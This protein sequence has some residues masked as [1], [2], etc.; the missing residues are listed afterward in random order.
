MPNDT[1]TAAEWRSSMRRWATTTPRDYMQ[2]IC[3]SFSEHLWTDYMQK[4]L[5]LPR[6]C[7]AHTSFLKHVCDRLWLID[8]LC[9]LV[10]CSLVFP[11]FA[12]NISPHCLRISCTHRLLYYRS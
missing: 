9:Y 6:F 5:A 4:T 12:V 1:M 2:Q 3:N 11:L 8:V 7:D 10:C